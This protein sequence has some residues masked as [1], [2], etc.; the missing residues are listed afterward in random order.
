MRGGVGGNTN[1]GMSAK[2]GLGW[3]ASAVELSG[4][5]FGLVGTEKI[6]TD[7]G[8]ETAG[9]GSSVVEGPAGSRVISCYDPD[10]SN[11]DG[12]RVNRHPPHFLGLEYKC[13]NLNRM[14]P[15]RQVGVAP[16]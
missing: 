8:E 9:S 11:V 2:K 16:L 4:T 1:R 12:A 13:T 7:G 6:E 15:S 5:T 3:G 14:D 10:V